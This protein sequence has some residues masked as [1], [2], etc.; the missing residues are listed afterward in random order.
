MPVLKAFAAGVFS[1]FFPSNCCLCGDPL[2]DVSRLP[3]CPGCLAAIHRPKEALCEKCGERL[4]TAA[5]NSPLPVFL[6][7]PLPS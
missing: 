3:V 5:A 7:I 2:T 1:V 4:A 6:A